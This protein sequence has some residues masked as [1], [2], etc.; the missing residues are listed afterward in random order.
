MGLGETDDSPPP[1]RPPAFLPDP[2]ERPTGAQPGSAADQG[3]TVRLPDP[4]DLG[5]TQESAVLDDDDD[6]EPPL[7][8]APAQPV[9]APTR[10]RWWLAVLAVVLIGSGVL[11]ARYVL[12]KSA[13]SRGAMPPG[14]V[15]TRT[16]PPTPA[17]S[18]EIIPPTGGNPI[19][20]VPARP[21]D[22]LS[23]WA[24]QVAPVAQ[25]PLVALQ[26]YGYAQLSLEG[27]A[28]LCHL[29]WTTLA[30]IAEVESDHGQRGAVLS[31]TGR[32]IPPILGPAL[33]GAGGRALVNDTDAGAFD[34]DPK[35]DHAMGPLGILPGAWKVY[36]IDADADGILDPYDVDDAALAMGRLLCAGGD[37]MSGLDGWTKAVGRQHTGDAYAQSVFN[38]ADSYGQR[39]RNVG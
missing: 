38:A 29:S 12:P 15:A 4:D 18:G 25:I 16:L 27:T 33:D 19:V 2:D 13:P 22:A 36:A 37:D 28:P 32:S 9:P 5:A 14:P 3:T 1:V 24:A 30:G 7:P 20:T 6:E 23:G 11:V 26:A 34:G 35:W 10:N 21:A 17:I 8:P 39:T 31:P